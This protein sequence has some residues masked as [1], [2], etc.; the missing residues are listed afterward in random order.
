MKYLAP[1]PPHQNGRN[2]ERFHRVLFNEIGFIISII[3]ATIAVF[4][5]IS[6]PAQENMREIEKL[7]ADVE[8]NQ[9][10]I[11][12]LNKIRDNDLHTIQGKTSDIE[13][14][15]NDIENHLIKLE[16]ILNERLP[17]QK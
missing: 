1:R 11:E 3:G 16:T 17:E 15:L 4:L 6:N 14:K 8:R 7:R 12:A 5:F 10:V 9:E 13:Q 2:Y